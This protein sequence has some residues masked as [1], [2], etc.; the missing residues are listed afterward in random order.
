M[1]LDEVVLLGVKARVMALSKKDGRTLWCTELPGGMTSNF[2]TVLADQKHVFA[3]TK[4]QVHCLALS[5]GALLWSNDLPGC[6]YGIASLAFPGGV[7]AP[8][9]G[10]VQT[11]EDEQAAASGSGAGAS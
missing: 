5:S 9:V 1:T 8:D 2:V 7:S 11:M 3:H 6:G 10:A 4:G